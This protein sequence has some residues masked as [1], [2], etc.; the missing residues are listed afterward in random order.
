M[1]FKQHK[2]ITLE[3]CRSEVQRKPHWSETDGLCSSASSGQSCVTTM[4]LM[5]WASGPLTPSL[6]Q[7]SVSTFHIRKPVFCFWIGS[8]YCKTKLSDSTK[9]SSEVGST[10]AWLCDPGSIYL[11]AMCLHFPVCKMGWSWQPTSFRCFE[12]WLIHV[13]SSTVS[14]T[15]MRP[16]TVGFY[17]FL[18]WSLI[19]LPFQEP[20]QV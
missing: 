20:C 14:G 5:T 6:F 15:Y 8:Q 13:Q 12:D 1:V 19:F 16:V 10:S 17:N 9:R 11:S 7:G 2:F 3:H 18:F 4:K